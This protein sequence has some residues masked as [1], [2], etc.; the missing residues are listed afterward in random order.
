MEKAAAAMDVAGDRAFLVS[1]YR[2]SAGI[3]ELS[4]GASMTA[5][6]AALVKEEAAKEAMEAA[7]RAEEAADAHAR[8]LNRYREQLR[9]QFYAAPT[10]VHAAAAAVLL[11]RA[12]HQL[13]S[14]G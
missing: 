12:S 9:H 3:A 8:L 10:W 2:A 14:R 4:D 1:R 11:L 13:E 6:F 7:I 5:V